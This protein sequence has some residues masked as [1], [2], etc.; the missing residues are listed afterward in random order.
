MENKDLKENLISQA[1]NLR[2]SG[3]WHGAWGME[4][5]VRRDWKVIRY[6]LIVIRVFSLHSLSQSKA[7][8]IEP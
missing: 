3:G 7:E 8:L 5:G 2:V 1:P 4:Q 6:S